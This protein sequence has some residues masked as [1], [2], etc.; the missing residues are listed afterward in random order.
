MAEGTP[1][2]PL[3]AMLLFGLLLHTVSQHGPTADKP[4]EKPNFIII[5]ADDIGWGDLD[6]NQLEERANNT[7][8]LNLM[9]LQGLRMTDFHSPASTCSP[10]RAAI[11][12]GRYGLRNGV[13]HNFGV[14]SLAGLPLSEVTLPQLLQK[15]G[16]HTAMIGKWHL[17]HNGL[18]SP[19]NRGFDYYLG[20]PFSNDMGC[21]DIPGYNLPQ[22]LPCDSHGPQVIR[23]KRNIHGG[24]YS[25]IGLPLI[26]NSTIVEQPLDLWTLTEQYKSAALRIIHNASERGQPYLLYIALAH[27]HVPLAP[28]LSPD[29]PTTDN[30]P[31]SGVYAASLRELDSLVGAI[32]N[33]SEATDRDNTL[34]WF[35]GDN[36]PWEQKCQYAGS[37]GPFRGKWQTSKGGGSAKQT[38]WEGG[39]RV[40]T[41]A[42][43]PGRIPANTTSSALLS[44]M[45]IFPTVLSLAGVTLP[46]DRRYDGI[47]AT[48]ILLHGEQ[49]GHEF[50]FHPNSG[51]A[52]RF[53]DLQTV[54][55]GRHKAFYITGAAEACSGE[56]G[57]QQVHDPP[58]IF[59]L[60]RDEAEETPLDVKT[61]E[62]QVVAERIARRREKLLWDIATD[63]SVSIADYRTDES[64]APCCDLTQTV[65]RC[66]RLG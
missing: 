54:R 65:C 41:V 2:L 60:E 14:K 6:A 50:L 43:W 57:K 31:N 4:K 34:I 24:C 28:P 36:G 5:L 48:N 47:D 13:T 45:D 62:Y 27:M 59:D 35:S 64:A 26:E 66:P 22:C 30:H 17:G 29:A 21:T 46:S 52:G 44:G 15:A 8:Y 10:S 51:A 56:T 63:K 37:V 18:Y 53:G 19:T 1:Q 40:P 49:L 9:A 58:L 11:L 3:A 7:P 55:S 61:T 12:T 33:A 38:T 16:Y 25:R 42:Y 39:H 23:L 32:K 20:I